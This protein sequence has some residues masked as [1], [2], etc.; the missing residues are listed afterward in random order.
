MSFAIPNNGWCQRLFHPLHITCTA[1]TE[2]CTH[3]ACTCVHASYAHSEPKHNQLL[4]GCLAHTG[5]HATCSSTCISYKVMIMIRTQHRR[6]KHHTS[7]NQTVNCLLRRNTIYN[8]GQQFTAF[9]L[10]MFNSPHLCAFH[11]E[12]HTCHSHTAVPSW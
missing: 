5:T 10:I 3:N 8:T 11:T 6:R 1:G 2:Q 9:G 7:R 12:P 4:I